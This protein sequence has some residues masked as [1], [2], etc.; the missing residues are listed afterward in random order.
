MIKNWDEFIT[1]EKGGRPKS[2]KTKDGRKIPGKY[3]TRNKKLMKKE[4]EEFQGKDEFKSD[5]DADYKSGKGGEGK[6]WK[7][8]KSKATKA[9]HD[10]F[11]ESVDDK[12][13]KAYK[14][15]KKKSELSGISLTILKKVY[16]R[17]MEAWNSGHRPGTPQNAWAMGRVN[18]F[19]TGTGKSRE[20]DADLWEKVD[21]KKLKK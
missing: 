16:K 1:E 15:L 5:W 19:I 17:G 9:F 3:L 6:R 13:S 7:T 4:I 2:S 12:D 11:K 21:K 10:M 18:S 14:A 20:A 8:K